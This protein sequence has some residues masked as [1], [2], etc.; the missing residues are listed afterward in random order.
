MKLKLIVLSLLLTAASLGITQAKH[1]DSFKAK[2]ISVKHHEGVWKKVNITTYSKSY[3]GT[4][5]ANGER[6]YGNIMT[7]AVPLSKKRVHGFRKPVIPFGTYITL[8]YKNRFV[9]VR[10]T[11]TCPAGTYDLST[12]AMKKLLGKYEDTK[13]HGELLVSK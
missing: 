7:V 1:S 8:R 13:L 3:E 9:K 4:L 2:T 10:V 6:Y 11:D 12:I 5:N